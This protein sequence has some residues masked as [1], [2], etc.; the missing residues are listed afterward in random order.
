MCD[1][2][3][4][5]VRLRGCDNSAQTTI[6]VQ[7]GRMEI[8]YKDQWGTICDE[9]FTDVDAQVASYSLGFKY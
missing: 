9:E 7:A 8:Y 6:S 5:V 4:Y 1:F 2:L 3:D